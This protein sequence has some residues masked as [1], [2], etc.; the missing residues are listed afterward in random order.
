MNLRKFDLSKHP[1]AGLELFEKDGRVHLARISRSTP[2][3][4]I[5]EWGSRIRGAWLIKINGMAATTKADVVA[6]L[7][8]LAS[9]GCPVVTMLFAHP[10]IHPSLSRDG[11]PIVSCPPF[12]RHTHEQMNNRW[13]FHTVTEHLQSCKPSY[14]LVPSGDVLNV[15]TRVMRLTRGKLMKQPDW[16]DWQQSEF[17]QLDLYD[18][19]SLFGQP[20]HWKED[21]AVF[22]TVWTYAINAVDSRKKARCTCDGSP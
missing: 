5:P 16:N 7:Q 6:I 8:N 22:H 18:A 11:V 9:S 15:I 14:Q 21:M 20:V 2:A 13:E 1:T 10:E 12:S 17:I 3:A 4:K 19:Q